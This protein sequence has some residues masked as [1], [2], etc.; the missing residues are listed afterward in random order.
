MSWWKSGCLAEP[1]SFRCE[2][3]TDPAALAG[4]L[5]GCQRY[6]I[7]RPYEGERI[8][9]RINR[10]ALFALVFHNQGFCKFDETFPKRV[11]R[12]DNQ[13]SGKRVAPH[14]GAK[15]CPQ[16]EPPFF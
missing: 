11:T 7:T 8:R 16:G 10:E 6:G 1:G 9:M 3:S 2:V 13:V 5:A 14:H 12:N 15:S 4:Q